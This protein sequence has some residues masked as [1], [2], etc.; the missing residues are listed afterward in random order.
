M[1]SSARTCTHSSTTRTAFYKSCKNLHSVKHVRIAAA[2]EDA[3]LASSNPAYSRLRY[4]Y[5]YLVLVLSVRVWGPVRDSMYSVV[6]DC[7]SGRGQW[8][9][10][11]R[12]PR[13]ATSLRRRCD[14][15][16]PAAALIRTAGHTVLS[17]CARLWVRVLVRCGESVATPLC[18][19][20]KFGNLSPGLIAAAAAAEVKGAGERGARRGRGGAGARAPSAEH[21]KA[22]EA[23]LQRLAAATHRAARSPPAYRG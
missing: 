19:L 13:Y 9:G 21:G 15:T 1:A 18:D 6:S 22:F 20:I 8:R 7:G 23:A 3:S 10:G 11:E 12:A 2:A 14:W 16:P 5:T 17:R 4:S